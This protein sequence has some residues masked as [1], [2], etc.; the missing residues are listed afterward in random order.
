MLAIQ[1]T[2]V[3]R[4]LPFFRM[5]RAIMHSPKGGEVALHLLVVYTDSA[6]LRGPA[7]PLEPTALRLLLGGG[8]SGI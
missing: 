3:I 7:S 4:G 1:P 8:R 5:P 2:P 6:G